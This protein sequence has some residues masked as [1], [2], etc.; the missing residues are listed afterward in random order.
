MTDSNVGTIKNGI[1][2]ALMDMHPGVMGLA[3]AAEKFPQAAATLNHLKTGTDD[4]QFTEGVEALAKVLE[5]LEE[6]QDAAM[7]SGKA[8]EE[9]AN[10]I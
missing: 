2:N 3:T 6:I 5:H 10:R 9:Y 7:K 4:V 8:L 1:L